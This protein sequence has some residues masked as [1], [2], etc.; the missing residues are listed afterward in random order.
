MTPLDHLER[1]RK[2]AEQA[3]QWEAQ[4]DPYA[5]GQAEPLVCHCQTCGV[6]NARI[7][8]ALTS[9]G[10]S[11]SAAHH[12]SVVG[13]DFR[14]AAHPYIASVK[15]AGREIYRIH[16]D[17]AEVVEPEVIADIE[18]ALKRGGQS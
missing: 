6:A 4:E 1:V 16:N 8:A 12:V 15:V 17:L 18:A 9:R 5:K 10:W 13:N 3:R 14:G 7:R 2:L 11:R